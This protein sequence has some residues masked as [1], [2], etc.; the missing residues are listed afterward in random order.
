LR[1]RAAALE[2]RIDLPFQRYVN[3]LREMN[4]HTTEELIVVPE[5]D[6]AQ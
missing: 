6:A 5:G 4:P 3:A 1:E 2:A